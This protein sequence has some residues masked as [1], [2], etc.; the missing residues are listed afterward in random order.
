MAYYG[1][2]TS[3]RNWITQPKTLLILVYSYLTGLGVGDTFTIRK[4]APGNWGKIDIGGVN[5]SSGNIL[6]M[7]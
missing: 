4:N 2:A 3:S 5:Y 6:E 1:A 7:L